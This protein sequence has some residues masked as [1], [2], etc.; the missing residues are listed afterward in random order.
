MHVLSSFL[1]GLDS[2]SS[3][4]DSVAFDAVF[5]KITPFDAS[6]VLQKR[7]GLIGSFP[8]QRDRADNHPQPE[9]DNSV[10]KLVVDERL[11]SLH[12]GTEY[13]SLWV[14]TRDDILSGDLL[15]EG[16]EGKI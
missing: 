1:T 15:I 7:V 11:L 16:I 2:L 6:L 5:G 13:I 12:I 8:V 9:T 4:L 10:P 3:N 14:D